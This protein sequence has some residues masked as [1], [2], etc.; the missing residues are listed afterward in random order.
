[1]LPLSNM[2]SDYQEI[3]PSAM[4]SQQSKFF[5]ERDEKN[6]TLRFAAY[7]EEFPWALECKVFDL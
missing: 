1:M 5:E 3:D 4:A 6:P 2:L 7:C